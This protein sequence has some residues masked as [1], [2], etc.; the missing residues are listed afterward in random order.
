MKLN[1][2]N[3]EKQVNFHFIVTFQSKL[4]VKE[5]K[6]QISICW[7]YTCKVFSL[8]PRIFFIIMLLH[9]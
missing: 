2:H 1:E 8:Y 4:L 6:F 7:F 9:T 3:L 5:L